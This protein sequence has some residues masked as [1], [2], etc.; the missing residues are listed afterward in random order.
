MANIIVEKKFFSKVLLREANNAAH[1]EKRSHCIDLKRLETFSFDF[2]FYVEKIYFHKKNE[3][4]LFVIIDNN[5]AFAL[6]DVSITR[7]KSL[8]SII[9]YEDNT[10]EIIINN[11]PYPNQREWQESEIKRPVR[12]QDQFRK[13]ILICY[14]NTCAVC[15]I[16]DEKI[17]KAAHIHDVKDGGD[18]SVNNGICLCA[19]HEIAFDKGIL[20]ILP[21]YTIE[22]GSSIGVQVNKIKLPLNMKKHPCSNNLRL[23][24]DKLKLSN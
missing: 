7:Y 9:F 18:D 16:D 21:D 20:K 19:N 22:V 4:R 1:R 17:L 6:L 24:L 2:I 11:R 8:P 14:N 15:N 3:I 13:E 12:K 23:K 10:F 5:G